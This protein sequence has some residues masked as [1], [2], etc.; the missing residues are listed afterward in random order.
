MCC[1]TTILRHLALFIILFKSESL[2]LGESLDEEL[3]SEIDK[4]EIIFEEIEEEDETQSAGDLQAEEEYLRTHNPSERRRSYRTKR[5][6]SQ[7]GDMLSYIRQAKPILKQILDGKRSSER[8]MTF[9]S[10]TTNERNQLK[11]RAGFGPIG[12]EAVRT[13]I[14]DRL[15]EFSREIKGNTLGI[16]YVS[17]VWLPEAIIWSI[18]EINH[19]N[20]ERAEEMFLEGSKSTVTNAEVEEFKSTLKKKGRVNREEAE[21]RIRRAERAMAC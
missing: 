2:A 13:Q 16:S 11:H 8:H 9:M 4:D 3:D 20:R 18:Q 19:V 15:V 7:Y 17:E 6:V 10:G 14:M 1:I 5:Q 21:K 12:N